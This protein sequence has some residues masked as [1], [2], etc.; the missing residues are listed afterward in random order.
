MKPMKENLKIMDDIMDR[1]TQT[2]F[3]N[4]IQLT[5]PM[6]KE[7]DKQFSALLDKLKETA[8]ED[9]IE[10]ARDA[11]WEM[12]SAFC[13]PAILYGMRVAQAIQEAA[14]D[15]NA[16]SQYILDRTAKRNGGQP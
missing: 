14:L 16:L 6:I 4:N 11:A 5:N 9:L 13:Y 1:V 8:P 2:D 10:K 15:P 12:S 3:W 7:A